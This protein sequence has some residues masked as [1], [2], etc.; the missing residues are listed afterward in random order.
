[1]HTYTLENDEIHLEFLDHGGII[2]KL[3]NRKTHTNYVLHYTNIEKYMQNPHFFGAMIGRN[4]G[5]TFPPFY[6]NAVGDLVRL[7]QN[8]GG[9]HLHGGKHGLHQVK[10]QVERIDTD[11]YSLTYQDDYSDY[12]PASIQIIYKLQ[13]NHFIIEISGY[14]AEPTVFNLTNHMYFNLNK[15]TAA[16]IETHWLQ[17]EDA[18]LQLIDEQCVPTGELADLDDPLYQAFDFRTRKQVGEALQIGTEL[19]E[20]CAGGIDLAYYFPKKSETVPRI[21]L[22]SA[23]RKNQ[24]KIRTNQEAAVIYTL[25]KVAEPNQE[26]IRKFGGI[27]FEMQRLP[28]YLQSESADKLRQHYTAFTDYELI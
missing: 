4:A 23:D 18:K 10:W 1:M 24:L 26:N 19:S 12:E 11:R 17:T 6:R 13:A 3:I 25:N 20:I 14:A 9:I 8:E 16:T 27:T 15:E 21:I 28:N 7:D 2:T 5:R 22:Q